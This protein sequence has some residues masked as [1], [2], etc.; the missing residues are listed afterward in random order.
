MTGMALATRFMP[1]FL[2]PLVVGIFQPVSG[3]DGLPL[4]MV[5]MACGV[6][7]AGSLPYF[8]LALVVSL[9]MSGFLLSL[10]HLNYLQQAEHEW[11]KNTVPKLN[12]RQGQAWLSDRN[13]SL[14]FWSG[15]PPRRILATMRIHRES[16]ARDDEHCLALCL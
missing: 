3:L 16:A 13:A 15:G 2:V 8:R 1:I 12:L 11:R 5:A 10:A 9:V 4:V 6:A 7:I 14:G